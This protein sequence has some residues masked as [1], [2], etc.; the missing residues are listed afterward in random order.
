MSADLTTLTTNNKGGTTKGVTTIAMSVST[1]R[2]GSTRPGLG[3]S[4]DDGLSRDRRVRGGGYGARRTARILDSHGR[5]SWHRAVLGSA[6]LPVRHRSPV[7][8]CP[9]KFIPKHTG[10][11]PPARPP[12]VPDRR[13]N[14]IPR[15]PRCR[16]QCGSNDFALLC[17]GSTNVR[18][19]TKR[20]WMLGFFSQRP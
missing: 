18:I 17:P 15:A 8:S 9:G 16:P 14:F 4:R 19:C 6:R 1:P 11:E 13:R 12:A 2:R 5:Q 10:V 7:G 20:N 3:S